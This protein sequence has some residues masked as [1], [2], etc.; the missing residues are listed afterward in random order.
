MQIPGISDLLDKGTIP[1][2]LLLLIGP[3]GAGKTMYCRQFFSDGLFDGD[4]CI[5]IS[6]SLTSKQFRSHFSNV[7]KLNLVQNS[8]F[9]NPYLYHRSLDSLEQYSPSIPATADDDNKDSDNDD[10][11][12]G[13]MIDNENSVSKLSLTLKDIQDSLA[14]VTKYNDNGDD[15]EVDRSIGNVGS[16]LDHNNSAYSPL[17][18]N[19]P[20]NNNRS[21]RIVVDSLTHLLAVFGENAVLKFVNDLSFLVKDAEAMAIFTLTTPS[22]SVY[23]TNAL[24]SIFD[25]IIEMKLE[26]HNEGL[27]RS[28]RL[29]SI[30]GLHYNPSWIKFK[31]IDDGSLAFADQSSSMSCMLCGKSISGP[32]ILDSEFTFDSQTCLETYKKLAGVYGSNISEIGLPSEVVDVNFFYTDIVSLSDPSLP[33]KKQM[34]KIGILNKMIGSCDAYFRTPKDKKIVL[35]TGDGMAIGFF[36]NPE[37]PFQLSTQLHRKLRLYNRGK[38]HE[39][40]IGLR[41]GLGSG[42]VF[43]VNDIKDNQNVWGPGIILA[44]RV[45]DIGDSF[46]ILLADRLA[47]DLIALKHEYRTTIKPIVDYKI[48]HGQ[49]I[50]L[51]SAYSKEFGNPKPPSKIVEHYY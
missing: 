7:E 47:E 6:S 41:I 28:V 42:P 16:T 49:T 23:L 43:V 27:N 14:K 34:E 40:E 48:K 31:I 3:A 15:G 21:V 9:I 50:K 19:P 17:L 35:T 8:K 20:G 24:S 2:S 37:L 36:L 5:Y 18:S 13:R 10:R 1:D 32:P 12:G 30:K 33:V 26:E 44:R 29:L 25:G 4:Y 11:A 39:D 22:T 51:Y 46:H 45:M 38:S